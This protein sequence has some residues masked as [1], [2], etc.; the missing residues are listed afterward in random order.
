[1]SLKLGKKSVDDLLD[2]VPPGIRE[3]LDAAARVNGVLDV[4]QV[5]VR[6][7]GPK[8]FADVTVAVPRSVVLESAHAV[9]SAAEASIQQAMPGTDVVVHVEPIASEEE[10]PATVRLVASRF[11]LGAHSIHSFEKGGK[12]SLALHLEVDGGMG[13]DA[14]HEL[15]SKFEQE[16]RVALPVVERIA[17]HI[18]PAERKVSLDRCLSAPESE[19]IVRSTI[20]AICRQM[21]V[22]LLAHDLQIHPIGESS[23][24]LAVSF[25]CA[26]EARVSVGEAHQLSE[27]MEKKLREKLPQV[28][29]VIIHV[30]PLGEASTPN[31]KDPANAS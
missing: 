22:R 5:R 6:R 31:R 14:A 3:K 18:E 21:G 4:L 27:E 17:S 19:P 24:E 11:G 8:T 1:V 7:S 23:A 26:M 30:E 15:V 2:A 10:L 20:E 25:S 28:G 9:A 13:L 16:L 12:L 29:R